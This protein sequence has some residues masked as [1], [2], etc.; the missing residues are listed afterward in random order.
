M[1]LDEGAAAK[2]IAVGREERG[3]RPATQAV[4]LGNIRPPVRVDAYGDEVPR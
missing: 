2:D 1:P 3:R 4:A